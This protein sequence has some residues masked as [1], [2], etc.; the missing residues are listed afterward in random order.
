MA[1]RDN[2]NSEDVLEIVEITDIERPQSEGVVHIPKPLDP[3]Q[4][5]VIPPQGNVITEGTR[6]ALKAIVK[7]IVIFLFLVLVAFLI[8]FVSGVALWDVLECMLKED[9]WLCVKEVIDE[10]TTLTLAYLPND[11]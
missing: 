6:D 4:G 10:G 1:K 2:T 9:R 3:S 7:Y 8:A 5:T 11:K